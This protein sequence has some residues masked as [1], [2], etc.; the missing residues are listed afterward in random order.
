[1]PRRAA[2]A[3]SLLTQA[4][5]WFGLSQA[6]LALYLGVSPELMQSIETGRRRSTPAVLLALL[7]LLAHL[8]PATE[9][10][11]ETAAEAPPAV[12][13]PALPP[14]LPAPEAGELDF[15]RR[16]CQQQ[17]ARLSREAAAIEQRARVV[18]H[19]VQALPALRQAATQAAASAQAQAAT[20]AAAADAADRAAWLLGWLERQAQPLPPALAT[21]WQLL[22]ARRAALATEVAALSA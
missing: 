11:L 13:L 5:A 7:P 16:V 22:Q 6:E 8:P 4:R 9:A 19:W 10:P 18:Q 17:A 3:T 15:R 20:P 2:P 1:M 12:T 14:G 21:R